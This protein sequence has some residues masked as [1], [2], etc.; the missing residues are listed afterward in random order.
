[1]LKP[2]QPSDV[3]PSGSITKRRKTGLVANGK[4]TGAMLAMPMTGYTGKRSNPGGRGGARNRADRVTHGLKRDQIENMQAATRHADLI[5]LPFT[6]M[7]TIHWQR[8]GLPLDQMAWATGR[9]MDLLGKALARKGAAT[10]Y[11]RTHENGPYKGGHCHILAHIPAE[12][13]SFV[14]RSQR[15]WLRLIT[16]KAYKKGVI[17]SKPIGGRLNLEIRNP[18]LHAINLAAALDYILKGTCENVAKQCN[19][20]RYEDGGAIIGKRCGTSANIN[21][22]A[23]RRQGIPG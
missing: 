10:A 2:H 22:A 6:R 11:V 18:E 1:M 15:G 7:I 20:R 17:R 4:K 23:R 9:F 13:V 5:G 3:A 19:L 8:A 12:L 16:G 21:A 14:T